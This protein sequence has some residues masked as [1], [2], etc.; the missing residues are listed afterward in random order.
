MDFNYQYHALNGIQLHVGHLGAPK[1]EKILLFLH[2]FP[3]FS[4]AWKKQ[5]VYFAEQGYQVVVPDQRGYYLSSKPAGIK[6]YTLA[7]LVEDIVA[8]IRS[9]T[10]R[11]VILVGHDWGGGVA[12]A[13]AQQHPSLLK[14]LVI[15]NMPH[16]QVMKKNLR[17]NPK[18]RKKSWY[19]AFFQVPFLPELIC[20]AFDYALLERSLRKTARART[21]TAEDLA[22]YKNAW[23]QPRALRSMINW[24]RAFR[25]NKLPT[26]APIDLP[27][28]ILWGTRDTFLGTEMAQQSLEKCRQ[29]K[30]V[31]IEDATHWLHHEKP[32]RVNELIEGFCIHLG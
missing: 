24:Y 2:G 17:H 32:D 9:L 25:L 14:G 27:T 28:L 30:L 11:Q 20:A 15:L 29:G 18:Q 21:F 13:L 23:R 12:W 5:A 4:Y 31:L 3:E 8:L 16:L 22:A 1:P 10:D 26:H 6:A 19:A 7:T